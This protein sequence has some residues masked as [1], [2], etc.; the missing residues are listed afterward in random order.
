MSGHMF[1]FLLGK[2][3]EPH[4][5]GEK[6]GFRQAGENSGKEEF[7]YKNSSVFSAKRCR[8]F[9]YVQFPHRAGLFGENIT[10][11]CT[12][13]QV[14]NLIFPVKQPGPDVLFAAEDC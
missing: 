12:D 5:Y 8:Y 3:F 1:A 10:I 2:I 13:L 11:F 6:S 9:S 14:K 4:F 7:L